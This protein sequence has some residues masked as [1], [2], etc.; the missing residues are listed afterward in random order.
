MGQAEDI[1]EMRD[2]IHELRSL[3]TQFIDIKKKKE[4][5]SKALTQRIISMERNVFDIRQKFCEAK[6]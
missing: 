4:T 3:L 5:Y 1:R 2:D 6:I